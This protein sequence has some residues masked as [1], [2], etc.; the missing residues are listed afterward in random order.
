[1]YRAKNQKNQKERK[2]PIFDHYWR[3]FR[4]FWGELS[5][6]LPYCRDENMGRWL[7]RVSK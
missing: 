7:F 6:I 5:N 3:Q 2:F 4:R 1:M